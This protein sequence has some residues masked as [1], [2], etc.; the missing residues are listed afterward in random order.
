MTTTAVLDK[1]VF[2][3]G[4]PR[5]GTT[6]LSSLLSA[7]PEVVIA[8]EMH[9]LTTW[10]ADY[11]FLDLT[12]RDDFVFFVDKFLASERFALLE[13]D[14]EPVRSRLISLQHRSYTSVLAVLLDAYRSSKASPRVGEKTP[15][16]FACVPELLRAFPDARIIW[17][18]RDPRAVISSLLTVPFASPFLGH[19]ATR[20]NHAQRLLSAIN[21][22]RVLQLRYEDLVL[23]LGAAVTKLAAFANVTLPVDVGTTSRPDS[24]GGTTYDHVAWGTEHRDKAMQPVSPASLTKWQTALTPLQIAMIDARTGSVAR[25]YGYEPH[26]TDFEPD[27]VQAAIAADQRRYYL[28]RLVPAARSRTI[29]HPLAQKLRYRLTGNG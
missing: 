20:W 13:L 23:D 29:D 28:R 7:S 25:Q 10:R 12:Q 3:V 17:M 27:A 22:E 15:G 24:V 11:G 21:D 2:I 6:L 18:V 8:P 19:K 26:P 16:Q 5:S 14:A 4:V 1:P 9:L